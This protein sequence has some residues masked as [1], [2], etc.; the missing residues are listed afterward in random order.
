MILLYYLCN[1]R[2]TKNRRR[3]NTN[4]VIK[5]HNGNLGDTLVVGSNSAISLQAVIMII[6]DTAILNENSV[7]SPIII[8]EIVADSHQSDMTTT[9]G[10]DAF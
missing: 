3:K 4:K 8:S 9:S 1:T 5:D 10:R 7:T 6:S 2:R